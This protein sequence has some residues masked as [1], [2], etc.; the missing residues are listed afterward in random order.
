MR[1]TYLSWLL[2]GAKTNK[3]VLNSCLAA[4]AIKANTATVIV[5]V[6]FVTTMPILYG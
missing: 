5:A 2:S 4:Q 1:Y 6:I 3:I